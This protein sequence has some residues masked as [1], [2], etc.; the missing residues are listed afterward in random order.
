MTTNFQVYAQKS[1]TSKMA[2]HMENLMHFWS[3]DDEILS[4]S[5]TLVK[6]WSQTFH[7]YVREQNC[8][9]YASGFSCS[10][11]T[12]VETVFRLDMIHFKLLYHTATIFACLISAGTSSSSVIQCNFLLQ[13]FA[14]WHILHN[15]IHYAVTCIFKRKWSAIPP[16][17][18][19]SICLTVFLPLSLSPCHYLSESFYQRRRDVLSG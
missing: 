11:Y 6:N 3:D 13:G 2:F 4:D 18:S 8:T 19:L 12:H 14:K 9:F 15:L 7:I 1:S 5:C 16:I 10:L 17:F